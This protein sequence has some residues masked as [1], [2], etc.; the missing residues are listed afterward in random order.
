M[1]VKPQTLTGTDNNPATEGSENTDV[2]KEITTSAS[3][4]D[5]NS[6]TY[7]EEEDSAIN[8]NGT[9]LSHEYFEPYERLEA[10]HGGWAKPRNLATELEAQRTSIIFLFLMILFV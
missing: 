6:M 10:E 7:R 2:V 3:S 9:S 4:P 1:L 5:S 8:F